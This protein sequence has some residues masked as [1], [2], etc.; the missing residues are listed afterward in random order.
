MEG[1]G[2][3]PNEPEVPLG[4]AAIATEIAQAAARGRGADRAPTL[5]QLLAAFG[6]HAPTDAARRRV[7]AALR[8]AGMGVRPDL[9]T[10]E[11]GQRLLL[12]PPGA[13]GGRSRGRAV[14]GLVGVGVVL[15]VA[16]AGASLLGSDGSGNDRASDSL[17]PGTT[18]TPAL[19]QAETTATTATDTA[20]TDTTTTPTDTTTTQTTTTPSADD[21]AAA[22]AA[23]RRRKR[24]ARLKRQ[25]AAAAARKRAT[26]SKAVTV[27][28]DATNRP[29]FLC[30]EDGKGNQLFGGTLSAKKVF[31]GRRIRINV[32]LA[33]TRITVNGNPVRL[34]GSPDGLD[35]T[36]AGGAKTLP[37][38][39]RPCS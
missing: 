26:A 6:E 1:S 16:A 14:L 12:L 33:S 28:V 8:V 23:E 15:A 35:I 7:A 30:V 21:Q 34:N 29:T 36:R 10:A 11:P 27:R 22:D 20:P 13:S 17:P 31:K 18:T 4:D 25:R 38:G 32:G 5:E 3:R 39:K 24:A 9:L 2:P 19:T 37:L